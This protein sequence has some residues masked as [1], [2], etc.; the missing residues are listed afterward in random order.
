MLQSLG[1]VERHQRDQFLVVGALV[2]VGDQRDLLQEVGQGALSLAGGGVVLAATANPLGQVLDPALRLD[3]P[4]GLGARPCSR[5]PAPT[6]PSSSSAVGTP[7]STRW[8]S[9][10]H[11]A[12]EATR[13]P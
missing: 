13:A 1:V 8:R 5:S 6:A 10:V 3:R 9:T 2:G 7:A 12:H 11:R 4:L